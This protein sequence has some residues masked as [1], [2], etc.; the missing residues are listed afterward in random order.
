MHANEHTFYLL[1]SHTTLLRK[2]TK[3]SSNQ[4]AIKCLGSVHGVLVGTECRGSCLQG[5][6]P[7]FQID[8]LFLVDER[9]VAGVKSELR[10]VIG[11]SASEGSF[12]MFFIS[13]R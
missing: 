2:A 10:F 13:L 1:V 4:K 6:T 3:K 7:C 8:W 9:A 12:R 5:Y 11:K